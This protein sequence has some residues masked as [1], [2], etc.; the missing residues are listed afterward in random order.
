MEIIT[1]PHQ[2]LRQVAKPVTKYDKKIKQFIADLI[3]TLQ[4]GPSRGVGLSAPQVNKS[5]R[6]FVTYLRSDGE[7]RGGDPAIYLNP[8]LTKTS[9][10][11]ELGGDQDSTPLEGCLSI[12]GIYGP[13]PRFGWVELEF[14]RYDQKTDQLKTLKERLEGFPARLAQHEIDHLEGILFTDHSL[15]HDLPLYQEDERGELIKFNNKV[16]VEKF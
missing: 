2:G 4:T 16:L 5:W 13:V 10:K 3:K 15:E 7:S 6:I 14:E 9:S 1:A 11:L 12:P 8:R